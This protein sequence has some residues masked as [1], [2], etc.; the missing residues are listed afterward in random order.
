[1]HLA[2]A[3]GFHW[4]S[5]CR[6]GWTVSVSWLSTTSEGSAS[7]CGQHDS[8]SIPHHDASV[9]DR[10]TIASGFSLLF[11]QCSLLHEKGGSIVLECLHVSLR[12]PWTR[13]WWFNIKQSELRCQILPRTSSE[14]YGF[15]GHRKA[16]T[17]SLFAGAM[18]SLSALHSGVVD[19]NLT[20]GWKTGLAQTAAN[21]PMHALKSKATS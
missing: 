4:T 20:C 21:V 11:H 14:A 12:A 1:M 8:F 7:C 6:D 19:T 2:F 5:P 16:K 18:T 3:D 9:Q 13:D 17:L 15:E 10:V